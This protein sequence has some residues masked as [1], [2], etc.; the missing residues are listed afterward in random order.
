MLLKTYTGEPL[1]LPG[2]AQVIVCYKDQ[3]FKLPLVVEK[4]DG[5]PLL[6]KHYP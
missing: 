2:E 3:K 6:V 5:P 4:G 1:K